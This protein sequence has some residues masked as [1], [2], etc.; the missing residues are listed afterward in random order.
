MFVKRV[1]YKKIPGRRLDKVLVKPG[2]KWIVVTSIQYPTEDVK[3][4]ITH[5]IT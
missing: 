5:N 3:V 2:S 4:F 1:L